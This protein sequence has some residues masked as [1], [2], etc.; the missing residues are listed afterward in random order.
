M[1]PVPSP[2]ATLLVFASGPK[3]SFHGLPGRAIEAAMATSPQWPRGCLHSMPRA[4]LR[5]KSTFSSDTALLP[6]PHGFECFL[7]AGGV[8]QCMRDLAVADPD[9]NCEVFRR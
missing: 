5:N 6:H 2:I 1:S 3:R 7:L 8:F 9:D 4:L